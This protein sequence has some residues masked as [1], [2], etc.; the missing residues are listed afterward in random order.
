MPDNKIYIFAG[1]KKIAEG[2]GKAL[3]VDGS[4][5]DALDALKVAADGA[6]HSVQE[7]RLA[8]DQIKQREKLQVPEIGLDSIED[9]H[10]WQVETKIS[11]RQLRRI[12]QMAMGSKPRLPR[13]LKKAARHTDFNVSNERQMT[14]FFKDPHNVS[15]VFEFDYCIKTVPEGYPR[16]R[17]VQRLVYVFRRIEARSHRRFVQDVM[18]NKI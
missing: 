14:D 8:V 1:G 6:A 12:R 10:E 11:K 15:F 3:A 9:T 5:G 7:L 16:T 4:M 13:K 2:V 17:W 18:H